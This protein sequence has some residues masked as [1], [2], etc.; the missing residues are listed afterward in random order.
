ML[1]FMLVVGSGA[2]APPAAAQ[3]S[4]ERAPDDRDTPAQHESPQPDEPAGTGVPDWADPGA[5]TSDFGSAS[6]GMEF[7]AQMN[8]DPPGPPGG[9][10]NPNPI[11]IDGGLSLLALV[12]AGYAARKLRSRSDENESESTL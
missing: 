5:S 11:P 12:G 9:G 8:Q 3:S 4:W 7:G 10:T 1:A 2:L 6:G